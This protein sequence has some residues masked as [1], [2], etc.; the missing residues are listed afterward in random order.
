MRKM[1][2][3]AKMWLNCGGLL[4]ILLAVGVIGYWSAWK[5]DVLV[6]AVQLDVQKQNLSAA[7][8]LAVEKEKVGGRDAILH[9]DSTYLTAARANFE[10]QAAMLQP[11]L[12]T[13]RGHRLLAQIRDANAANSRFRSGDPTEQSWRPGKVARFALRVVSSTGQGRS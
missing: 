2:L 8:E 5:T 11:L 10:Q 1:S 12:A 9:D 4:V 7:I 6:R 3:R 13:P